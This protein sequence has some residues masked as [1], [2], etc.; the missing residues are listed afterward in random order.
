MVWF[1]RFSYVV[2]AYTFLAPA[3]P[4]L[5][6]RGR[7]KARIWVS[8]LLT[9]L[10]LGILQASLWPACVAANCGQGAILIS[11][12]WGLGGVSALVTLAL[13]MFMAS[14]RTGQTG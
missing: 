9:L 10:F 5:F 11:F 14:A 12:M 6:S 3:L 8:T 2:L 4:W 13:G 1:E 7:G